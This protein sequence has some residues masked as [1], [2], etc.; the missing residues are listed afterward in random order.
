MAQF[1]GYPDS[2]EGIYK[3][4]GTVMVEAEADGECKQW[5]QQRESDGEGSS[6]GGIKLSAAIVAVVGEIIW[7]PVHNIIGVQCWSTCT[8]YLNGSTLVCIAYHEYLALQLRVSI[9]INVLMQ[10][11]L[12][13]YREL[14]SYN[15]F[16]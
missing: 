8:S 16:W 13:C 10:V 11:L 2:A 6:S 1:G 5:A 14:G 12:T 7:Y 4:R 9:L 15:Y 3:K